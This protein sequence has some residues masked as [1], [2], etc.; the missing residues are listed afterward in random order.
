MSHDI[1]LESTRYLHGTDPREQARLSRLNDFL[2]NACL[3]EMNLRGGEVILDLGCGI[4]QLSRVMAKRVKPRGRVVG[5]ERSAQQQAEAIRQARESGE[6]ALVDWRR[7]DACDPPLAGEEWGTF[8][9]AHARYVLEHVADP[10]AVVKTMVRAVK[11]GGRIILIDDDHES[12]HLWPEPAGLNQLWRAYIRAFDRNGNDPHIGR[13]LVSLLYEAGAKPVRN[14]L[15]WFGGCSGQEELT[16]LVENLIGLLEGFR[17]PILSGSLLDET[18]FD[19]GIE[20]LWDW[21]DRPDAAFW[22]TAHW[23]E[24]VRPLTI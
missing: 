9:V 15:I 23:A 24:G 18:T 5:V 10:L 7:G 19:A 1:N 2:N 16:A 13:R 3:R 12:M 21:R 22:F 6:E 20:T 4:G 17:V 8:D 14:H 11:P